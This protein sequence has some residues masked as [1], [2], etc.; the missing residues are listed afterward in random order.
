MPN[1]RHD[2]SV[3]GSPAILVFDNQLP[4]PRALWHLWGIGFLK[5][6]YPT[7]MGFPTKNDHFGV[8]IGVPP[9]KETPISG[10]NGEM[11]CKGNSFHCLLHKLK[12]SFVTPQRAIAM[13]LLIPHLF[14]VANIVLK[15][16]L[17]ST[18]R[19]AEFKMRPLSGQLPPDS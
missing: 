14:F 17:P 2:V 13:R 12:D 15:S 18:R 8:E 7:T 11:Y 10:I 9:F 5:W 1:G 3:I 19:S 6:S 4:C 16:F